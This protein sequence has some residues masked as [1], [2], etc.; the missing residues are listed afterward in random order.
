[1]L[2]KEKSGN[3]V[4]FVGYPLIFSIFN[5]FLFQDVACRRAG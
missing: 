5:Q 2:G 1:M 3:Q 4:T